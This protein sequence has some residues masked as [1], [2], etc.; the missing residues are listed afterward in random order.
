MK[1]KHIELYAW[2]LGLVV[3]ALAFIAWGQGIRWQFT[4]LS[5]YQ[6]FPIFGL[7]AFSLI[8]SVYVVAFICRHAHPDGSSLKPYYK[9]LPLLIL[10]LILI[11]PGLLWFQLWRDGFGLPPESY[12]QHYVAPS[13]RW[14]AVVGTT[15]LLIFITYELRYKYRDRPWWKYLEYAADLAFVSLF[16]H[17]L[18]L[19]DQLRHGW[20]R[21]V[22]FFYGVV[23]AVVLI[24]L[25]RGKY[26][27]YRHH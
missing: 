13:L 7:T 3:A 23:L 9:F 11:H 24:D 14:A 17:A 12:L 26:K 19:G 20:F 22:W 16:F 27:Q 15:A 10:A 8:W 21:Y 25:Y 2:S 5:A 1:L 18:Y 6:I 4:D